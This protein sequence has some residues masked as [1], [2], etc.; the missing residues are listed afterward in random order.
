MGGTWTGSLAPWKKRRREVGLNLTA[1]HKLALFTLVV[2]I[3]QGV[4]GYF[5]GIEKADSGAFLWQFGMPLL[6]VA[7]LREDAR[8]SHYWPCFEYDFFAYTAWPVV[9]PHY[10]F[11]TR[12]I[13]GFGA[14]LG[15]FGLFLVPGFVMA[16]VHVLSH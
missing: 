3:Q 4:R 1:A 13:R 2:T 12:G 6:L 9:L 8:R 7:W 15:F 11:H 5:G 14:F 16:L 10:L